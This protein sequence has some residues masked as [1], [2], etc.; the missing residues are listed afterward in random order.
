MMKNQSLLFRRTVDICMTVLLLFLMGY[1]VT[2]ELLHEWIGITMTVLTVTHQIL[3]RK[4]YSSIFKGRYQSYRFISTQVDV[5]LIL[6]FALAAFSG[7]S[8]SA[9]AVPF[10]YGLLKASTARQL[11]LALS[12]WS[13][14]LMGLH[15]GLHVPVMFSSVKISEKTGL[16]IRALFSLVSGFG[17]YLMLKENVFDYMF[18]RVPFAFLDYETPGVIVFLQ[19]IIKLLFWV[20]AGSNL[21]NLL[22][23]NDDKKR[24]FSVICLLAAMGVGLML[25]LII[26]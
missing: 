18:F 22:R 8:M 17:L 15:I 6:S 7:M 23:A 10:M 1:Q 19:N 20:V 25:N 5:L 12:H 14:V 26:A 2:G 13:F 4:W 11:H 24:L 21:F 16:I 9:H 3:N